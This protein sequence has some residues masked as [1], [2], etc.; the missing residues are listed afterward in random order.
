[1][2]HPIQSPA[3]A[4]SPRAGCTGPCPGGS[5]ISPKKE[6]PPP[7]CAAWASA[8]SP[9][10][11]Q[12]L[13]K[14]HRSYFLYFRGLGKLFVSLSSLIFHLL[15]SVLSLPIPRRTAAPNHI[16]G[17]SDSTQQPARLVTPTHKSTGNDQKSRH[18]QLLETSQDALWEENILW[19]PP[20][21]RTQCWTQAGARSRE[22]RERRVNLVGKSS[23]L[24]TRRNGGNDG[25]PEPGN[26]F[27]GFCVLAEGLGERVIYRV[28]TEPKGGGLQF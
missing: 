23:E 1:V 3:E 8:P 2:G 12:S 5:S 19:Y 27:P 26:E 15:M 25:V 9:S 22:R 16:H 24:I 14:P 18:L 7:P 20:S 17:V 13:K 6:T 28:D 21:P 10:W 4:G 11:V